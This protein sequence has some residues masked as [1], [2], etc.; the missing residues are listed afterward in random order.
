MK[1]NNAIE[2]L[3]GLLIIWIVLYHFTVRYEDIFQV[4]GRDIIHFGR[5]GD[6]GVLMFFVISGFFFFKSYVCNRGKAVCQFFVNKYW[7]LWPA[8]MISVVVIFVTVKIFNIG[9]VES[10]VWLTSSLMC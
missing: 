1:R 7:R 3:R 5:G 6:I 10:Q 9:G 8:Y 2:A 4:N